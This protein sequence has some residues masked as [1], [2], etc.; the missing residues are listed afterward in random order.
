MMIGIELPTA[1]AY[2]ATH[3]FSPMFRLRLSVGKTRVEIPDFSALRGRQTG[4]KGAN[5]RRGGEPQR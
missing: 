3:D 2:S 4:S 1:A 5:K